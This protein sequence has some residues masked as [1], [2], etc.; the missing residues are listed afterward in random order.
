MLINSADTDTDTDSDEDMRT[1]IESRGRITARAPQ[2]V[3]DELEEA[4]ALLGV[5]VNQFLVQAAVEKARTVL[6]TYSRIELSR[7]DAAFIANLL[8]NPPAPNEALQEAVRR[9][10]KVAKH[11]ESPLPTT[12]ESSQH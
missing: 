4:A 5:S 10:M 9:Y 1:N 2:P 8:D 11:D 6:D 7:R 3:V 12:S